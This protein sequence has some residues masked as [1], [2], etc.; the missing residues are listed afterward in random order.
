MERS[1]TW[2]DILGV[3]PG[4]SA[5]EIQR[6]YDRKTSVL[7]PE[8]LSG[9]TSTVLKAASRAQQNLDDAW[10][11]LSDPVNRKRYDEAVGI[12][13]GGEGLGQRGNF[14]SDPGW[15]PSD[16]GFAGGRVGEE[17]VGSL[18]AVTE[19]LAPH[20]RQPT[21]ISVPDVQG[22]FYSVCFELTSR[23]GL[24]VTVVRLT[25]HPMAVDGIVVD[26]SPV[27]PAKMR[28]GKALTVKVW[29]PAV[30]SD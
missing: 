11:A 23:L 10:L 30:R 6:G 3:L 20:P 19:W 15:G 16:F 26:Q 9:A 27:P 12:R 5:E 28:R 4:A 7:R 14:P 29:H 2:Y 1:T 13:R 17:L 22:L 24:A 21:R 8:L 25:E 18:M